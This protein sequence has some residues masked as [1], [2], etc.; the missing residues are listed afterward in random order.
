MSIDKGEL[1]KLI[2][3]N[4]RKVWQELSHKEHS[5]APM[6]NEDRVKTNVEIVCAD[7]ECYS[8]V[9]KKAKKDFPY[10]CKDCGLPLPRSM[11]EGSE[12]S[13]QKCPNCDSEEAEE[14]EEE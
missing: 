13:G 9:I 11:V 5:E 3:D 6:S 1:E 8:G 10:Q 2:R 12:S 14:R 7:G 4:V